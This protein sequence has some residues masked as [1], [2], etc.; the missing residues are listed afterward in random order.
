MS[1]IRED[2][3]SYMKSKKMIQ[4]QQPVL[5]R[6]LNQSFLH[7]KIPHAFLL[8]GKNAKIPAHFIAKSIIC[9]QDKLCCDEC[10]DCRRIDEHNYA[11]LIYCDGNEETIKKFK[12]EYIQE[13]FSK[14]ALEGKSKIYLLENIENST[15]EA[16][17]SLLKVLEEPGI[18]V[19]AIF[20]CQNLNRVLPTIQSR[21]QIIQL[22]PNSKLFLKSELQKNQIPVDD[23]NI[24]AELF[25]T[26]EEC[27]AYVENE[28]FEK[29]KIEVFHFIEDLYFHHDNLIINVQTHLLKDFKDKKM[30]QL[31]LNMLV[32]GLR[33]L[34]HVKQSMDLIYPSFRSLYEKIDDENDNIIHKIDL[35]LNTEY[36]L[37]TNANVLLLMDSLM[38]R[39]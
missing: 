16:M 6:I 25:D 18:G 34:F 11:D 8:V 27:Q 13:Q 2:K 31:F 28:D 20:T 26:Y 37:S 14:S 32:L 10:N 36:L 5:Y 9:S 29:L 1:S 22:L 19:Y 38:Y 30:I 35:V 12:I 7:Q 3:G 21:C 24:L 39:I 15:P 23:I 4:E 17:N 33:D